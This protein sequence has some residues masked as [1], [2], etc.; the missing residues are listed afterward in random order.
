M[1]SVQDAGTRSGQGDR[2]AA[3]G[4]AKHGQVVTFLKSEHGLTHGNAN[5]LAHKIR[6][7]AAGGQPTDA[8]LLDAQ[9]SGAKA[10]LRPSTT[11]SCSS[12]RRSGATSPWRPRRPA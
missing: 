3:T 4:L 7:N 6:E 9:Y 12:L 8:D 1:K 11:R 5:T 10:A 2:V